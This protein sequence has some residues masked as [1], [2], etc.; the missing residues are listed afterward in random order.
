M[1]V[2]LSDLP[3]R[4][5]RGQRG[6]YFA[7]EAS[8]AE[9]IEALSIPE[10][11][12]G[13]RLWLGSLLHNGYGQFFA[14]G[15]KERRAHRAAYEA[16]RGPIPAGLHLD[17]RCRVR[18]CVEVTH[19]EPVTSR[20]NTLRGQGLTAANARKTVCDK[21]HP[22]AGDNLHVDK[23]GARRCRRCHAD[24]QNAYLSRRHQRLA[25]RLAA[26]STPPT[27]QTEASR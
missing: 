5:F 23:R 4:A 10:P 2:S 17:H 21:G 12:T 25:A 8:V 13:C 16:A 27:N 18:S 26:D 14:P 24:H 22:L 1:H 19:L 11:N 15:V 20:E 9:R 7:R 6:P 3:E